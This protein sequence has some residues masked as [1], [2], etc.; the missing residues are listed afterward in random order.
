MFHVS[1]YVSVDLFSGLFILVGLCVFGYFFLFEIPKRAN[2]TLS[3]S[4]SL[5]CTAFVLNEVAASIL[6]TETKRLYKE[7]AE[8]KKN[9]RNYP[10][11]LQSVLTA[12]I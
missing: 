10:Q 7:V 3:W 11:E 12:D 1:V 4:F 5:A 9:A 8:K 2:W 6:V